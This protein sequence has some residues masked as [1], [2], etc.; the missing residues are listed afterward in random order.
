[1]KIRKHQDSDK[2][3]IETIAALEDFGVYKIS[4]LYNNIYWIG[5]IP[6]VKKSMFITMLKGATEFSDLG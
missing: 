5:F 6:D 3:S 2:M 1:M 4:E